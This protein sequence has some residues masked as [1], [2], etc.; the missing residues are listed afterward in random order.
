MAKNRSTEKEEFWRLALAEQQASGLTIKASCAQQGL[1]AHAFS[2]W[3]REIKKRDLRSIESLSAGR[4]DDARLIPVNVI[5]QASRLPT[6]NQC[7]SNDQAIIEVVSPTGYS[8]RI[9][10][11]S[12]PPYLTAL[13]DAVTACNAIGGRVC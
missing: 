13:L 5:A 4:P 12:P 10:S 2:W 1:T 6:P 7:D 3:K 11:E 8:L 9:K